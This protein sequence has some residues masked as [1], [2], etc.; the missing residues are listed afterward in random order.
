MSLRYAEQVSVGDEVLVQGNHQLIPRMV[1]NI[2]T[3]FMQGEYIID[4]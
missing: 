1:T 3:L 4:I 2:S